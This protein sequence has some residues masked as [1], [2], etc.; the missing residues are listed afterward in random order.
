MFKISEAREILGRMPTFGEYN[1]LHKM[2]KKGFTLWDAI[3][4]MKEW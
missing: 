1:F 3:D 4:M 2:V